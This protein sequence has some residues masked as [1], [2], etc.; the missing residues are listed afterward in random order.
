MA[1]DTGLA[2]R[3]DAAIDGAL[4]EKRLVGGVVLVAR[5]GETVYA[6][7][8][9]YADREVG[10]PTQLDTVFRYASLSKPIVSAAALKLVEEGRMGI[11][12]PVTRFL[13]N[14]RPKM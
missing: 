2:S 5:D 13:P 7:A 14:F 3:M 11:E 1:K 10:L 4:A 9:G 8:A 6:R 12:D